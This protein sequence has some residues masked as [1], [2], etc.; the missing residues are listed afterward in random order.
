MIASFLI[1]TFGAVL[2]PL[3]QSLAVLLR[4]RPP[5]M[6]DHP[7]W[8]TVSI[9]KPV[10]G[11]DDDLAANLLTF[12][13]LDYPGYEI[14]FGVDCAD[15]ACMAVI[16]ACRER[17]PHIPVSIV[18]TD[19]EK[20]GNPKVDTLARMAPSAS[21]ELFWVS[22]ANTRVAPDTLRR[23]VA[24]IIVNRTALVFSPIRGAG[25]RTLGSCIEN[26]YVNMFVS[27]SI[28]A[29]WRLFR[30]SIIVGKSM[31][32]DSAALASL[33]GFARF[34]RYLAEDYMMGVVFTR[35]GFRV[36]TNGTWITNHNATTSLS[37]FYARALRWGKMR[38]TINL[39]TYT[40]E[41]CSNPLVMAPLCAV[42]AGAPLLPVISAALSV[43]L[44][45]EY[46]L[47][48]S[49]ASPG[50]RSLPL[51]SR[52]PAVV[53]IKDVLLAGVYIVPFFDRSIIWRGN[54][55][56]IGR[57]SRLVPAR[58]ENVHDAG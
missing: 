7:Q 21:G 42:L 26:S 36:A 39:P 30:T 57:F 43:Q 34:R 53:L 17:Y 12:F 11:I 55:L 45:L 24:E 47:L 23:L 14:V 10:K 37:G 49:Q 25:G 32:I 52:L 44:C 8:P 50:D 3:T 18:V 4:N 9:L 29:G 5:R 48:R 33:G 2:V 27:G 58:K 1:A 41:A 56:R 6:H 13:A 28:L 31:L 51:L 46:A 15:D 22:D 19:R 54:R 38:R 35:H 40:L 16:N 20:R